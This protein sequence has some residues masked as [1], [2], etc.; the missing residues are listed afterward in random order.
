MSM[1]KLDGIDCRAVHGAVN[2]MTGRNRQEQV[3]SD[4]PVP[5][6]EQSEMNQ[7]REVSLELPIIWIEI[8]LSN[9]IGPL[10]Y[11]PHGF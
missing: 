3:A 9:N 5:M 7:N 6:E 4:A 10:C 11:V 2:A 8:C 1:L